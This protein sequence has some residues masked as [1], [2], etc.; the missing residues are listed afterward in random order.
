MK[1]GLLIFIIILAISVLAGCIVNNRMEK[2]DGIITGK[3]IVNDN[4]YYFIVS[5]KIEGKL[6]N[7]EYRVKVNSTVFSTYGVGDSYTFNRQVGNN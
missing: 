3:E 4:E 2:T 7:Y 6:G 5:Y 1:K